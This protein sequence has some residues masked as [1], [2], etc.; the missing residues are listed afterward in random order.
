MSLGKSLVRILREFAPSLFWRG[1]YEFRIV[2]HTGGRLDI[3]PVDSA[4]VEDGLKPIGLQDVW[5]GIAGY[6]AHPEVGSICLVAFTRGDLNRP[7]IVGFCPLSQSKP[8]NSAIDAQEFVNLG[9]AEAKVH[10]VG[11][12]VTG[13]NLT[14]TGN[15]LTLTNG[16]G[17]ATTYTFSGGITITAAGA[18]ALTGVNADND[19]RV[20]A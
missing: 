1:V 5:A 12:K 17:V 11:D 8:L 20:K 16:E 13:G 7:R 4:D 9:A 6:Q 14:A 3:E 10:R 18:G 15:T 19:S 2:K